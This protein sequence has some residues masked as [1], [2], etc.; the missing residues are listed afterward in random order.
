MT[1]KYF[2]SFIISN[3]KTG[4][5]G[6]PAILRGNTAEQD[7]QVGIVSWAFGCALSNFPGG[8]LQNVIRYRIV[9]DLADGC[10]IVS[11]VCSPCSL[12][13]C[14]FYNLQYILG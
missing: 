13:Y 12:H 2:V 9:R 10:P 8:T 1:N 5:S 11:A 4:D 3:T 7:V 6:G 14:I